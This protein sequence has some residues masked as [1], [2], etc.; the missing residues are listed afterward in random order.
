[1]HCKTYDML[2]ASINH[3][4][5]PTFKSRPVPFLLSSLDILFDFLVRFRFDVLLALLLLRV[6]LVL[7]SFRA[8]TPFLYALLFLFL[9][10]FDGFTQQFR[11]IQDFFSSG[12]FQGGFP[13]VLLGDAFTFFGLV[14]AGI[15]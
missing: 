10:S 2:L 11:V 7:D 6:L 4:F 14:A 1:M 3:A 13:G 12:A 15:C 5:R 9:F 8:F